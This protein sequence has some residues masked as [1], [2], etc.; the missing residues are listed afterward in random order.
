M[1]LWCFQSAILILGHD[2]KAK[3]NVT[4]GVMPTSLQRLNT[5]LQTIKIVLSG[6]G[7]G[8]L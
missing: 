8:E 4:S 7:W 5:S 6:T 3:M 1:C 2:Y